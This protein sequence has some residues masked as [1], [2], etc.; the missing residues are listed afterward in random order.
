MLPSS[1]KGMKL[2]IGRKASKLSLYIYARNM[3]RMSAKQTKYFRYRLRKSLGGAA[4][5]KEAISRINSEIQRL[6]TSK[7]FRTMKTFDICKRKLDE[8]W[9]EGVFPICLTDLKE[10]PAFKKRTL[11]EYFDAVSREQEEIMVQRM[12]DMFIPVYLENLSGMSDEE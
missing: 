6:W 2:Y 8:F 11:I 1:L 9:S 7:K 12:A 10:D 4:S 3:I 5:V